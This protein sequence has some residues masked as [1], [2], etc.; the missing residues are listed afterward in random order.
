[1]RVRAVDVMSKG[2]STARTLTLTLSRCTGRGDQSAPLSYAP[3]SVVLPAPSPSSPCAFTSVSTPINSTR[4]TT[5]SSPARFAHQHA[6]KFSRAFGSHGLDRRMDRRTALE[7]GFRLANDPAGGTRRR[8]DRAH[9]LHRRAHRR[10]PARTWIWLAA[11]MQ[12]LVLAFDWPHHAAI[13]YCQSCLLVILAAWN[14]FERIGLLLGG[15]KSMQILVKVCTS[16]FIASIIGI[17]MIEYA[18]D[19]WA[20]RSSDFYGHYEGGVNRSFIAASRLASEITKPDEEIAVTYQIH[21]N[22]RPCTTAGPMRTFNF[23]TDR[24]VMLAPDEAMCN[25]SRDQSVACAMG[26]R[27]PCALF[28][29]AAADRGFLSLSRVAVETQGV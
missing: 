4:D 19:A 18:M 1:M 16:L 26:D 7:P 15:G 22:G 21:I 12:L 29:L 6:T 9:F 14:G 10:P 17:N 3:L 8:M 25:R 27:S 28:P 5:H 20:M 24:P 2:T 13:S 23:L 11:S